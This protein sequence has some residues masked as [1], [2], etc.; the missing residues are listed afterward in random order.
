MPVVCK[1]SPQDFLPVLATP[2]PKI[3][4][5]SFWLSCDQMVLLTGVRPKPG[6]GPFEMRPWVKCSKFWP[7]ETSDLYTNGPGNFSPG[8]FTHFGRPTAENYE[9][10]LFDCCA[11]RKGLKNLRLVRVKPFVRVSGQ[12][13]VKV[14]EYFIRCL[15]CLAALTVLCRLPV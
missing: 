10:G 9:S 5:G 8:F 2:L 15:E 12:S 13:S 7:G 11:I 3:P 4:I 14:L 6:F 1:V